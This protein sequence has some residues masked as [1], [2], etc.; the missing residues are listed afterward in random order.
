MKRVKKQ[1]ALVILKSI[2]HS[3]KLSYLEL[4]PDETEGIFN[5]II[6][7]RGK[8]YTKMATCKNVD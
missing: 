8:R 5:S 1:I 2:F 3:C 4:E 7:T 6:V